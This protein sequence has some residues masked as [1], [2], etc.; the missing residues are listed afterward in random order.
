MQSISLTMTN[1]RGV[2]AAVPTGVCRPYQ[3]G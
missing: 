3:H 2:G 1:Q